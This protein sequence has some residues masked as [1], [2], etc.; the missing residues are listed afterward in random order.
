[1]QRITKIENNVA[2][3][4]K[5]KSPV[6]EITGVLCQTS[7]VDDCKTFIESLSSAMLSASSDTQW[8]TC[9]MPVY[10]GVRFNTEDSAYEAT[11]MTLLNGVLLKESLISFSIMFVEDLVINNV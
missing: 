4:I 1:M 9:S 3:V 5:V 6:G 7:S 2:V 8:R 10:S 11:E